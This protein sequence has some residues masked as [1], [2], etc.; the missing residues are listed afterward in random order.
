MMSVKVW[1]ITH[2]DY[3]ES[4]FTGEGA[5]LFGGRFNSEGI[6]L[7]YTSGNL[8]LAM[9]EI[10]VQSNG[11]DYFKQCT[12]F[13]AEIPKHL[14]TTPELNDL[15]GKWNQIPYGKQSQQFGDEWIKSGSS[16][17][18][19]VPSV[20][21]PIEFNFLMNP[22]HPEFSKIEIYDAENVSFDTRLTN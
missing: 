4:A 16:P 10:M 11:R 7:V 17:V 18:L 20:V 15:P 13:Y 1:R 5:K 12:V 14:I 6:P 19:R 21:V 2:K 22:L 3:K 9:L 8:S